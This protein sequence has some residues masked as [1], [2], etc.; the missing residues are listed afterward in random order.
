MS[1]EISIQHERHMDRGL[2]YAEACF[3]TFRVIDGHIF[4][5]HQHW[6]RLCL[7]LHSFGIQLEINL[8]QRVQQDCLTYA[9]QESDDCLVR[10][11]IS[12]GST[13]WGLTKSTTPIV[14][15]Q[16]MPFSHGDPTP[17]RAISV[18]HPFPLQDK[19]AKFTADYAYTL[20]ALQ[21][22][23][24]EH[25]T[26]NPQ[27][28]I[29]CKHNQILSGITSNIVIYHQGKWLTPEGSG[30]LNGVIRDFFLKKGLIQTQV[31]PINFLDTCEAVLFLNSGQF[32]RPI[33]SINGR[34]LD[35][36]HQAISALQQN[37]NHEK[38]VK[39]ELN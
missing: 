30:I 25:D 37:L 16:V 17:L 38:G 15:I 19:I 18:E 22:W 10:L 27:Q 3:E 35:T 39:I 34:D 8:E 26:S 5:W 2:A 6:Q 23:K 1:N 21:I 29:V 31:C 13:D 28:F 33:Q 36:Q 14:R 11:T 4:L 24:K 20:K 32:L 9:K 12:G 7:G